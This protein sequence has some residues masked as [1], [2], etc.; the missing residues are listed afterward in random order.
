MRTIVILLTIVIIIVIGTT[1]F[2]YA[3]LHLDILSLFSEKT[4]PIT[5]FYDRESIRNSDAFRIGTQNGSTMAHFTNELTLPQLFI[6]G[7]K[8]VVQIIGSYSSGEGPNKRLG[9]G[10]VYDNNAHIITNYH[11]AADITDLNVVFL[12]GSVYKAKIVGADTLTD[13]TVLYVENVSKRQANSN[14]TW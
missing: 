10:F 7:Q 4:Q 3:E 5:Y 13:L 2:F 14:T 8:S 9:S 11:V 6:N 12:D 1:V